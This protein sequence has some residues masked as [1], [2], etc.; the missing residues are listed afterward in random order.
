MDLRVL[1]YPSMIGGSIYSAILGMGLYG[2]MFAIPVF[3]QDYLRY[4]AHKAALHPGAGR[5]RLRRARWC[6]YGKVA[7]IT[8]PLV[9]II[10][11]AR[12]SPRRP[13]FM[14]MG[15]N[16]EHQRRANFF[17]PLVIRGLGSVLMFMPLS[18][19]TLGPLPKRD[20]AA[21]AGIY[22]L[23]RQLGS[24]I[25]I[26]LITTMISRQIAEHRSV[27]VEKITE[28]RQPQWTGSRC[29]PA[30]SPITPAKA[31]LQENKMRSVQNS[32]TAS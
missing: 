19:A 24:S 5:H 12:C 4:T 22:S 30:I 10:C 6:L 32:S 29:S 18:I 25:G 31:W 7:N 16:H 9:P 3:V 11:A 27:L 21:G 28:F 15:M 20:I 13:A 2:I 1:R 26:A 8:F 17:W 23:T 14:L